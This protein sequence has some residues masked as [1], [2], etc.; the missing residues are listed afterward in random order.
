MRT[1]LCLQN[2]VD[3]ICYVN[4][5]Y[6]WGTKNY[7]CEIAKPCHYEMKCI[8]NKIRGRFSFF[9][10][11]EFFNLHLCPYF[12]HLNKLKTWS[13]LCRHPSDRFHTKSTSHDKWHSKSEKS[14]SFYRTS[15]F[16]RKCHFASNKLIKAY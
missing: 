8:R 16:L 4:R 3:I 9:H 5:T 10:I 7:F 14:Q 11:F 6:S 2:A 15:S 12:V 13:L 1:K